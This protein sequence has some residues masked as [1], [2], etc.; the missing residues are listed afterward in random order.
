MGRQDHIRELADKSTGSSIYY[1]VSKGVLFITVAGD[2]AKKRA[3]MTLLD[4]LEGRYHRGEIKSSSSKTLKE[5]LDYYNDPSNDVCALFLCVMQHGVN[6]R[7]T[8]FLFFNV[9]IDTIA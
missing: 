8:G 2:Q 5:R 7:P 3:V 9:E 4:D 6:H 1:K